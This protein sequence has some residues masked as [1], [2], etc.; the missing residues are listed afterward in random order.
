VINESDD[1]ML[2]R[3]SILFLTREEEETFRLLLKF[4]MIF[5]ISKDEHVPLFSSMLSLTTFQRLIRHY[6]LLKRLVS[7]MNQHRERA[8][9]ENQEDL[10][11]IVLPNL[12]R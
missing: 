10:R 2:S 11:W 9:Q 3:Y 8:R 7:S 4:A 1:T 6:L 12:L 5:L